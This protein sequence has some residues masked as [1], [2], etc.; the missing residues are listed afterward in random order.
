VVILGIPL[1]H[2][3]N[4]QISNTSIALWISKFS[5]NIL[6]LKRGWMGAD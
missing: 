1:P 4:P 5:T 6:W 2:K 3:K